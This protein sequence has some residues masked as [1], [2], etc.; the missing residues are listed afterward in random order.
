MMSLGFFRFSKVCFEA[1][2]KWKDRQPK[3]NRS[4]CIAILSKLWKG[5]ELVFIFR[6]RNKE[7]L[8]MFLISCT[9]T[10]GNF[11]LI[12]PRTLKKQLKVQHLKF[13]YVYD[14]TS[15]NLKFLHWSKA[16][17]SNNL[18]NKTIFSSNK[19]IHSLYFNSYHMTKKI[20]S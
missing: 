16:Q 8:E 9:N 7:E 13:T 6:N 12:L 3:I 15:Q 18:A 20:I 2:K 1:I 19:L 11:I 5:L 10:W 4:H 14:M 17:K